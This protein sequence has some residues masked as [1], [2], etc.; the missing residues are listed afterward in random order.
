MVH[1][2]Y[3]RQV[4]TAGHFIYLFIYFDGMERLS[5]SSC[6]LKLINFL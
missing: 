6:D 3:I 5:A 1:C 4:E 2:V